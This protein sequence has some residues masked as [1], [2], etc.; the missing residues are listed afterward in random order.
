M[1]RHNQITLVLM[2][3]QR[4]EE[5]TITVLN[6]AVFRPCWGI[7]ISKPTG[8]NAHRIL[9]TFG[10]HKGRTRMSDRASVMIDGSHAQYR[11]SSAGRCVKALAAMRA[12]MDPIPPSED[13]KRRL[14]DG[15]LHE[16]SI[17]QAVERETGEDVVRRQDE[18]TVEISPRITVVGHVDGLTADNLMPVEAK[19]AS[20]ESFK[21]WDKG[22]ERWFKVHENYADQ[23]TLTLAGYGKTSGIYA[24][25][26]KDSGLVVVREIG[27]QSS[28]EKIKVRLLRAD[29]DGRRGKLPECDRSDYWCPMRYLHD[30][31]DKPEAEVDVDEMM[32]QLV[33][34]YDEAREAAKR[35][36]AVQKE[37]G[38]R[39]RAAM[40]ERE[41][42]DSGGYQVAMVP[43]T[44]VSW[45]QEKLRETLGDISPFQ[46]VNS[47]TSLRV[48]KKRGEE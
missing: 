7:G 35:T 12:G 9:N 2:M 4:V 39:L 42:V 25:K 41:R 6:A 3:G 40:G 30:D 22:V 24:V 28:L 23:W 34:S 44:R 11:A 1:I 20:K 10:L 19:S 47:G 17:I 48:T 18:W 14:A 15:H 45:D 16:D 31:K 46:N 13:L 27:A 43:W 38:E 21:D 32:E 26:N 37:L 5:R 8:V 36:E 29:L 33:A